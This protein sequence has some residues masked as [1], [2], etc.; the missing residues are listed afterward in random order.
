MNKIIFYV[1]NVIYL[2]YPIRK[3]NRRSF[4]M[5]SVY[6]L[7]FQKRSPN[8]VYITLAYL[9]HNKYEHVTLYFT[10]TPAIWTRLII[11]KHAPNSIPQL[12]DNPLKSPVVIHKKPNSYDLLFQRLM[13]A[14]TSNKKKKK[15]CSEVVAALSPPHYINIQST[16]T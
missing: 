9:C 2:P 8:C 15:S 16:T 4:N 1:E 12:L 7:H 14:S 10:I 3:K 13:F 11:A 5:L 6:F